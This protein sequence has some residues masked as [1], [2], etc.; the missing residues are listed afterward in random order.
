MP[1]RRPQPS[2]V[3]KM[4]IIMI[5]TEMRRFERYR[6]RVNPLDFI[7]PPT[8][9][10][11]HYSLFLNISSRCSVF[12]CLLEDDGARNVIILDWVARFCVAR[13]TIET[14]SPGWCRAAADLQTSLISDISSHLDLDVIY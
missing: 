10:T 3:I 13:S 9:L 7:S 4:I 14:T 8:V 2:T 1:E 11:T 6:S 5:I 12:T